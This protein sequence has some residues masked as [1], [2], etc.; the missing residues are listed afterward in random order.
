MA[1]DGSDRRILLGART[2][3]QKKPSHQTTV[4]P[5]FMKLTTW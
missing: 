1:I 4:M 2:A 5:A 3:S